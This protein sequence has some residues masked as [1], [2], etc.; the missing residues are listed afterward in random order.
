V[1]D[2]LDLAPGA[3]LRVLNEQQA[4]LRNPPRT[5]KELMGIHT[6]AASTACA[7]IA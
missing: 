2:L 5:L 7:L 4:S 3:V 6:L 1:L